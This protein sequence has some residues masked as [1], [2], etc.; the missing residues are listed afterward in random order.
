MPDNAHA[1]KKYQ[2]EIMLH[3]TDVFNLMQVVLDEVEYRQATHDKSKLR[4]EEFPTYAKIIPQ[5][6]GLP[7]GSPESKALVKKLGPALQ[8]HYK[9]NRHHPEHFKNGVAGMHLIDLIEMICDWVTVN[10]AKGDGNIRKAMTGYLFQKHGIEGQLAEVLLNTVDFLE[11][12]DDE[13]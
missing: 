2:A 4:D 13:E 8:H 3:Q 9:H 6:E 10:K 12:G 5:M 11:K 1:E 7:L